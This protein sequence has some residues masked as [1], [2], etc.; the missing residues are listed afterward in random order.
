MN[1]ILWALNSKCSF[2]CKYCYLDFSED[3]NPINNKNT[4]NSINI[5]DECIFEFI[6]KLEKYQITRV[7]IAGAEPLSNPQK[8]LEI[9]KRIKNYNVQVV[10]CTNGYL[11]DKYYKEIIESKVDALSISLDS[12]KKDYNDKYR[13]YPTDD[14]VDRVIKGIKILKNLSNIKIGIYTVLTRLN[15]ED[16]EQTY[17]FVSDLKVDYYIFSTSIFK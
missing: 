5:N 2:H 10:L 3:N 13:Q 4:V 6:R 17:K 11:I 16:L 12:Y 8:T 14:G 1:T 15:L 9:I 7:F